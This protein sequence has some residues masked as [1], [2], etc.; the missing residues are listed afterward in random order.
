[1]RKST[2]TG[3]ALA[4]VAIAITVPTA[5]ALHLARTQGMETEM[6]RALVYA[7]DVVRRSDDTAT[8][9]RAGFEKL[10]AARGADPCVDEHVNLM[11]EID[12]GST[13]LQA[14]GV[15]NGDTL[16]CSSLGRHEPA[17]PLGAVDAVSEIGTAI[18]SDVE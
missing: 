7:R 1:M 13:Y 16:I 10:L 5:L 8:Q 18:R 15:T 12:L 11:H 9:I 4:V 2:A 3:L 6:A 17:I 14:I